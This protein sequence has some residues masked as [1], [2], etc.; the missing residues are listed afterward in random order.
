MTRKTT[1]S[2]SE[3]KLNPLLIGLKNFEELLDKEP[4]EIMAT[5]T[6]QTK[7][8]VYAAAPRVI[9][10]LGMIGSTSRGEPDVP[11]GTLIWRPC[12]EGEKAN[13]RDHIYVVRFRKGAFGLDRDGRPFTDP[14]KTAASAKEMAENMEWPFDYD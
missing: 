2:R 1:L 11:K 7:D 3:P 13:G 5:M 9:A 14:F 6:P 4:A 8:E 10:W 12:E